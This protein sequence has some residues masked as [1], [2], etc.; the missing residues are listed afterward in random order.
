MTIKKYK[1]LLLTLLFIAML[2]ASQAQ[3]K[4]SLDYRSKRTLQYLD[5][6]MN[7]EKSMLKVSPQFLLS[8]RYKFLRVSFEYEIKLNKSFTFL[9]NNRS[10][11]TGYFHSEF[12]EIYN[13]T[14]FSFRY[15]YLKNQRVREGISGNNL[16]GLYAEAGFSGLINILHSFPSNELYP[17]DRKKRSLI[18]LPD[19]Y[20]SF[21]IQ[22]RINK[23]S[24]IDVYVASGYNRLWDFFYSGVGFNIGLAF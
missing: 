18:D 15:Y 16:N 4:D 6:N 11:L 22:K 17:S 3:N 1:S 12:N 8:S 21:G 20:L 10:Q 23:W 13:S 24:F 9:V 2:G 7:D 14:G 19:P 5:I